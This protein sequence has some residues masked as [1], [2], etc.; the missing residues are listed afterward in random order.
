SRRL[1]GFAVFRREP[2]SKAIRRF[3]DG[4]FQ[5]MGAQPNHLISDQGTQFTERGFRRW[6]RRQRIQHRFGAV[7][8][9][10]SLAVIERAIRTL[11]SECTRRLILIPYRL[12]SFEQ[13]LALYCSWYNRHRPH[14][15]LRCATPDE[16]YHR[17]RQAIRAPRFEPRRRWPRRSPCASPRTLIRGQPGVRLELSVQSLADR[18]HLP[19]VTL[20]RVA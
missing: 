5:R 7:G 10:G 6:C 2:S 9:Y 13:E 17:R 14:S 15:W 19:I 18:S 20:K 4:V 12:G 1:M 3:L 11:K 16:I 8:K